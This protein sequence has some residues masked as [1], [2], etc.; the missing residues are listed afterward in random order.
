MKPKISL[1]I[2]FTLLLLKFSVA[3]DYKPAYIIKNQRDTTFGTGFM[4]RDQETCTFKGI[5][6]DESILI[7]PEE[8]DAFR[9]IDGNYYVSRQI[10]ESDGKIKWYFL[11]FL[12]DGEIDLFSISYS[13]RYFIKKENE[14]FLEL[15]DKITSFTKIDGKEYTVK[16]HKYIGYM[17]VYMSDTPEL[18]PE[19]D[20]LDNLSQRQLVK[21]STDYHN[22]VCSDDECVNYTKKIPKLTYQLEL[23]T[24]AEFHNHYYSPVIGVLLHASKA[25]LNNR[26]SL[27]IGF[28]YSD[29]FY[30]S[31]DYYKVKNY[32]YRIKIPLSFQI[33]FGHKALKPTIAIGFTTGAI[34]I[35]SFQGGL[36]YSISDKFAIN[37]SAAID[38]IIP[39]IMNEHRDI[40]DNPFGHTFNLGLLYK[41]K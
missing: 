21:I 34:Y 11:E 10:M 40:Y 27:N 7:H 35:D 8:I 26:I 30:I 19:I 22:A 28:L 36:I 32:H 31:K 6:S 4:S 14:P 24:G 9:V 13:K 25:A 17:R 37:L 39:L 2:I 29:K 5:S 33:I 38:G 12:V 15:N 1:L 3:Q 41:I 20:K 16:D 23:L 18:Y